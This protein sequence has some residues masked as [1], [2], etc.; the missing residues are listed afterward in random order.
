MKFLGDRRAA[1]HAAR[2]EHGDF[3]ARRREIRG[4]DQ[5]VVTPA[6]DDGVTRLRAAH[7]DFLPVRQPAPGARFS[8]LSG[9]SSRMRRAKLRNA[10]S[11]L[12]SGP[13]L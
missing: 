12:P 7:G 1:H 3:E 9:M 11:L 4:A 13:G 8:R 5:P 6:D 10:T 2:L